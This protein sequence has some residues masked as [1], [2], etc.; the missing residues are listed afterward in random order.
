F[1]VLVAAAMFGLYFGL[2]RDS[3][4]FAHTPAM[5]RAKLE[6]FG[7]ATPL[8][9]IEL[10]VFLLVVHSLAEEYYWR[11]FVFGQLQRLLPL[12]AAIGVSS[13]GFMS[14]HVVVLA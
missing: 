4:V 5:L 1:G 14:H 9:F 13:L 6:E 10:A 7:L 2:L 12:G 8:G 3:V 11:W